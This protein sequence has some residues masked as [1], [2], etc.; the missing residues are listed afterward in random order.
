MT[1]H[2]LFRT[3]GPTMAMIAFV[4]SAGVVVGCTDDGT[5]GGGD[6]DYSATPATDAIDAS[7]ASRLSFATTIAG[8]HCIASR[9]SGP[10]DI[11]AI[12]S[13][14]AD[15]PMD[16]A[17]AAR[18]ARGVEDCGSSLLITSVIARIGAD[19]IPETEASTCRAKIE[20]VQGSSATSVDPIPVGVVA[21]HLADSTLPWTLAEVGC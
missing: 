1:L 10:A 8:T 17:V 18:L 7:L 20:G 4:V 13:A 12:E 21:A 19:G 16:P 5:N 14:G 6:G 3:F 11:A 15:Q 9:L 2:P